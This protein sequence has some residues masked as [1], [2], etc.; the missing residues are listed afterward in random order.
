MRRHT[1]WY[2]PKLVLNN[3]GWWGCE[4]LKQISDIYYLHNKYFD[5]ADLSDIKILLTW[6]N[7]SINKFFV[8]WEFESHDHILSCLDSVVD[9]NEKWKE[10][11]F[12]YQVDFF[13][14]IIVIRLK[15]EKYYFLYYILECHHIAAVA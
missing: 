15:I 14:D 3:N 9:M 4:H 11:I 2:I 7:R 12:K 6:W 1:P 8:P 10:K 5:V 13:D